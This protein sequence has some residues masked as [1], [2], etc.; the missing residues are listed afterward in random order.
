MTIIGEKEQGTG[1]SWCEWRRLKN[2]KEP[3]DDIM[4]GRFL[5]KRGGAE[6]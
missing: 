6:L 2:G 4:N 1:T 5:P 3:V